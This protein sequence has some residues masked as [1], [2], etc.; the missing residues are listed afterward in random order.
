[1]SEYVVL[2]AVVQ[3]TVVKFLTKVK[4]KHIE[5][6]MRL[7][8]QFDDETLSRTRFMTGVKSFKEG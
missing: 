6:L 3:R 1:M 2:S 4:V 8:P 5:I 7:R